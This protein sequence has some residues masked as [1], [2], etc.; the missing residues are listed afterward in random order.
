MANI[1][2]H[3]EG[4][5]LMRWSTTRLL[6]ALSLSIVATVVTL[7]LL[8]TP[9]RA[10]NQCVAPGGAGGCHA[11]IQA[12][13]NAVGSGETVRV[14][15][16]TYNEN[17]VIT[18]SMTLLG[19]YADTTF[20]NRTPRSSII[21]GGGNSSVI[22]VTNGA[23]V[24]ID[25]FTITGGDATANNG[26]GGGI[27]IRQATANIIDNLIDGNV[28][29]SDPA[30]GG[31]GG[32]ID[33]TGNVSPVLI[34]GNTILANLAYSVVLTSPTVARFGLGGG[35]WI[36]TSSS[37]IITGNQILSNVAAR[38][39]IPGPAFGLGGGI[40]GAAVTATIDGNA[41][42]GN[43][44]NAVGGTGLGGGIALSPVGVAD[45]TNNS[46][47]EN[48]AAVSGT[49]V[50][51]GGIYARAYQSLKVTDNWV[52]QNT[53]LVSGSDGQGGGMYLATSSEGSAPNL[54]LTG[55]WV[56]SNTA[57][58]SA[59]GSNL[60]VSGGGVRIW[61]GG[62]D[63]DTLTMQD[64]HVID[65]V[66][67]GTMTTSG[68][69]S[70]GRAEGGGLTVE[71][72]S[73]TLIIGNEVRGNTAVKSLFLSGSGGWG[74]RP[75]GGGMFIYGNDTVALSDNDVRDNVT[76]VKH[77]VDEVSSTS[78]GGGIVLD[79]V[80][81]ADVSHNTVA[82]NTAVLTGTFTSDTGEF[83]FP[84]GGGIV[85]NCF[86]KQCAL[87]FEGNNILNNVTADRVT[88]G[89]TNASGTPLGGG[90][91]LRS[92]TILLHSNVISGN[93]ANLSGSDGAGGAIDVNAS[94]VIMSQNRILG[95]QTTQSGGGAPAVWVWEG[96]LTSSNDVFARNTGGAGSAAGGF[97]SS[98]STLT[99]VND[100]F[101]DN[102]WVGVE[103]NMT[104]TVHITNTIVYS[105]E[106]GLRLND[107]GST[108][109]G[110]YNLLSNTT[111]YAGGVVGG[112]NDITGQNPLFVN[113]AA[114][115][116][117]LS[118]NSPA[119]D[120]GNDL[121]APRVD[122]EGDARPIDGD[123][124]GT[125]RVDIGAD[126]FGKVLYLPVVLKNF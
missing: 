122:F 33:V 30:I 99:F 16:G 117:H 85:V 98:S 110:D 68:A 24:T 47:V 108:L 28:A 112:P 66:A 119:I 81:T 15:V 109:I 8:R 49:F 26:G 7:A 46:V 4:D 84:N 74:G 105:H 72:I 126:E 38:T 97:S 22:S 12:A 59:T 114:Y 111:N 35:I 41:I 100:T 92:S 17:V 103:A 13:V 106:D 69:G 115:D 54:V 60:F 93:M 113:A 43:I 31:R 51:G 101:Y 71:N 14:V 5:E 25:G 57:V 75:S 65:N 40:G 91:D 56:M 118:K 73:I 21:N 95:N 87:S 36:N 80:G 86:D 39:D 79:S 70:F 34:S 88:M 76:A 32:G 62:V 23:A 107:S 67:G 124:N 63:N 42:Q 10:A 96:N 2:F 64:N 53:A 104:S 102:G 55:N 9:V 45:V 48:T 44:A 50:W 123:F 77:V 20:T 27:A 29:S 82:G 116:F 78:E 1:P 58:V 19:G 89:G 120:K 11:T 125:A 90:L 121:F 6:L 83:Y 3:Y 18:K 37:A 94:T 61:G 52:E